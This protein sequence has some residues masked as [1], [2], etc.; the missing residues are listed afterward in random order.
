ML[1]HIVLGLLSWK[2]RWRRTL[3]WLLGCE[4][5]RTTDLLLRRL[6]RKMEECS[7]ARRRNV[8]LTSSAGWLEGTVLLLLLQVVLLVHLLYVATLLGSP[9]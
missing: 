5:P 3:D 1:G 2:R 7:L 9:H 4:L 8:A 6:R